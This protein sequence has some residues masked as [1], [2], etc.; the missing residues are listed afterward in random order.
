LEGS[1]GVVQGQC[2]EG[3]GA[4]SVGELELELVEGF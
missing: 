4:V 3:A 2:A 1:G